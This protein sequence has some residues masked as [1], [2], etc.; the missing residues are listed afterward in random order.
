[1]TLALAVV[2]TVYSFVVYMYR[3]RALF[4]HQQPHVAAPPPPWT[5]ELLTIG[6]EL[7]LGF[8]VDTNSAEIGRALAASGVQVVAA[9]LGARRSAPR[10][11]TPSP[12]ALDRT[13]AVIAT[14][15][16][17][18]T[19]DDI[20][21]QVVADLFGD[22]A[23]V[24]RPRSGQALVERFA[25]FGT[26]AGGDES[27]A[28]RRCRGAR[29]CCPTAGAP[30]RGSGSRASLGLAILLPGV[31]V[32]MRGLLQH[33]VL[34]APGRGAAGRVVRSLE[35]CAPPGSPS[36]RWPSGWRH[37]GRASPRSP[38]PT[39]PA[40]EGVDLRLTAWNLPPDEADARLAAGGREFAATA[41]GAL[42]VR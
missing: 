37:R 36:P 29:P 6:T 31:P 16:L 38:S 24:S 4:K 3:Y 19:A 32:E 34:P 8:T 14:G 11:V 20:T 33:E 21:K 7:L 5:I 17:G 40:L 22:A 18:P 10:S 1:M 41:P 23:R 35:P 26:G 2:L 42:G 28:R 30:R 12:Q 9:H 25:R 13:G 39:C 15:G 27:L